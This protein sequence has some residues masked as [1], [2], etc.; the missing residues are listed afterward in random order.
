MEPVGLL[1][2]FL[3]VVLLGLGTGLLTGLSPGLH[4][5]NVA[6][7]VLA[8]Q[9]SWAGFLAVLLPASSAGAPELGFLL[10]VFVVS[11][12]VSHAVFDF[13]PSVFFGA[14]SEDTALA[15]LPGH[16]LLLD[17]EGARAVA[18]AARGA[19]LGS[20]LSAAF[21]LPLRWI[22]GAP[23]GLADAFRPWTGTF[24]LALLLALLLAETRPRKGRVR[25]VLRA[26]WVQ[27]LAGVLGVAVLRGPPL[28]DEGL[29]LFPLFSGLFGMPTLLLSLR[30]R[31]GTIPPQRTGL[32]PPLDRSDAGHALRGALAG[33]SVSWLP[34]L[35]GGAAATLAAVGSRREV[36]PSGFMV[37]LGAVSTS[38]CILSISVLFI[39]GK[40]RSGA[41]AA[42]RELAPSEGGWSSTSGV[43]PFL[44]GILAAA[45]LTNALATPLAARI[46]RSLAPRWSA[47]DPRKL[48]LA[49]LAGLLVL[50]GIVAGPYGLGIASLAALVGLV[51]VAARVRRV[52][53]M[54]ALLAPVL[55]MYSGL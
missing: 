3:L 27:L 16:R 23:V 9:G 34:G 40:A 51:P 49:T 52:H 11:T 44:L 29:V 42:I 32:L 12:A 20:A 33:A 55:L 5:N 25:R 46:G 6:A 47:I 8:T 31:P 15:V 21:V 45:V 14:P 22:L 24:L 38:T 50:L 19:A 4:V 30:A 7:F 36:S 10:S 48:S 53:L 39:L 37:V 35:S 43:P 17:G 2:A 1:G 13:V 18:L 54:A 26:S 28:L 41:A